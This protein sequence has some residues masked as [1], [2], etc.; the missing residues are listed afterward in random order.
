MRKLEREELVARVLEIRRGIFREHHFVNRDLSHLDLRGIVGEGLVFSR[1]WFRGTRMDGS[2]LRD[3]RFVDCDGRRMTAVGASWSDL[4]VEGSDFSEAD[5]SGISLT[6]RC[7]GI[8]LERTILADAR[9]EGVDLFSAVMDFADLREASLANASLNEA[10]L[11]GARLFNAVCRNARAHGADFSS[12]DCTGADFRKADVSR[13]CF[14]SCRARITDFRSAIVRHTV[15][16]GADLGESD[17]TGAEIEGAEFDDSRTWN[18]R[19]LASIGL[20]DARE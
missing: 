7:Q 6:G 15:F 3:C 10:T 17:F 9:L 8:R 20:G 13:A 11:R 1:C 5:L 4:S 14:A 2:E 16:R 12:A 19:G 18:A